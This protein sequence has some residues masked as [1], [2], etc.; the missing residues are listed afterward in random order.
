M[1][2]ARQLVMDKQSQS[3]S[4]LF[5]CASSISP[6]IGS[7]CV[8]SSLTILSALSCLLGSFYDDEAFN[9]EWA[10]LPFPHL[11]DFIKY[12]NSSD[13]HPPVSYV[14]NKLAFNALG[15]WKAVQFLNGVFNAAAI[16][17]FHSQAAQKITERE[18]L[19]LT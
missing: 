11:V 13:I 6:V 19:I 8:F 16:A 17:L 1:V 9:I 14:L 10:A 7:L 12:I 2:G 4:P 18:R 15:S 5:A 3:R